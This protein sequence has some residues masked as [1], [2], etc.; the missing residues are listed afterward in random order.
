MFE[1]GAKFWTASSTEYYQGG[2]TR[3]RQMKKWVEG[4]AR[5]AEADAGPAGTSAAAAGQATTAA[6]A[7]ATAAKAA[8][9]AIAAASAA[10]GCRGGRGVRGDHSYRPSRLESKRP[11]SPFTSRG[12]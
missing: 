7:T 4:A 1:E 12:A 6:A 2:T 3:D 10:T 8:A 9:E 5:G 11:W